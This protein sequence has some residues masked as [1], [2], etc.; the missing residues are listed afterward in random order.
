MLNK[1]PLW[2]NILIVTIVILAFVYASPNL[3]PDNPAI[4]ISHENVP[5]TLNDVGA[6]ADALRAAGISYFG[7]ELTENGGL[8]RFH[9]L[10]DQLRGKSVIEQELGSDY[11]VAL[12]L[13]P[14]TPAFLQAIGAGKINLGLDLQGGVHFLMEVDMDTAM[15]R[16]MENTLTNIRQELRSQRIRSRSLELVDT[17]LI[18]LRFDDNESRSQ[19]RSLLRNNFSDLTVQPRER[20]GEYILEL[21]MTQDDILQMQRDTVRANQTSI[22]NRVDSLGVSEPVVQQQGPN[23]IVVELPGVQDTAQAKRILQRIATLQ[24]HLEATP[25][26]P[27]GS[28]EVYDYQGQQVR[29]DNSVILQGD[30]ISNVRSALDQYGQPQVVINLDAQGGQQFNRVTRENIGRLMDI[31]LLETR[32]RTV[33]EPDEDGNL[34]ERQETYEERRLISHATIRAALGREFVI[35]GLSSREANDLSL[36]IRSGALAAPMYFVEERTVGPSLGAENIKQGS[37]AVMLGYFLV[38]SFML[39]YYRVFGLAANLALITNVVLLVAIMSILSATLTLPGIF[40]IVLTIGMAVDANVLIFTRIREE[41]GAGLSPQNAISAGFERAFL[42]IFDANVTSFLVGM[43]L[44]S[45]GTGPV[46]GFAVTFM[47][48]LVT[49]MFSGILVTR[50]IVNF[51]Y[52]GKSVETLSIGPNVKAI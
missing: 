13:A 6:A 43:V 9:S 51:I 20:G 11:I 28:Y 4:Q 1:F 2:K 36:L 14:T 12:N 3:F 18:A 52:G 29:V 40:G 27:P 10:E 47:V 8:I 32:T 38:L 44:F 25:T 19:A 17:N 39:F 50:M 45:V 7:D 24:F 15:Q 35:T 23:R 30:R 22:L 5:V 42:T 34:V 21:S 41:I 48:G 37:R 49:S 16:R 46:K 31:L 33:L 26:A